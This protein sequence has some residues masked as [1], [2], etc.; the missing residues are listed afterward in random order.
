MPRDGKVR[1]DRGHGQHGCDKDLS[2]QHMAG[3]AFA[4]RHCRCPGQQPQA[5]SANMNNQCGRIGHWPFLEIYTWT[6][7]P[8]FHPSLSLIVG[9]CIEVEHRLIRLTAECPKSRYAWQVLPQQLP[10][11]TRRVQ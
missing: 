5:P 9:S 7:A 2:R 1:R 3:R 10:T 4:E 8:E 11:E 6:L